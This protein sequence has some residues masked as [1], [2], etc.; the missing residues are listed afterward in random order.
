M[1][2]PVVK[3]QNEMHFLDIFAD[4]LNSLCDQSTK[5]LNDSFDWLIK[6]LKQLKPIKTLATNDLLSSTQ[7]PGEDL[8]L[9]FFHRA[10]KEAKVSFDDAPLTSEEKVTASKI[11]IASAILQNLD[12]SDLA[13]TNFMRLLIELNSVLKRSESKFCSYLMQEEEIIDAVIDINLKLANFMFEH[14]KKR[15]PF[16]EWPMIEYGEQLIHTFYYK[17][18]ERITTRS[19]LWY[20]IYLRNNIDLFN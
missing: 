11:C 16:M 8:S 20:S 10:R 17:N 18:I 9:T 3:D 19:L 6:G 7:P 12:D 5:Y 2:V 14:T 13:T 1:L 15:M 4:E